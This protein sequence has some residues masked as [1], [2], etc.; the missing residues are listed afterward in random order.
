MKKYKYIGTEEQLKENGF[1]ITNSR[2]GEKKGFFGLRESFGKENIIILLQPIAGYE[3]GYIS[4]NYGNTKYDI[5]PYIQ[6]LMALGL[7]VEIW[8]K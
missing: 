1:K 4:D 5:T 8:K 2:C 7:V 3:K 6:D